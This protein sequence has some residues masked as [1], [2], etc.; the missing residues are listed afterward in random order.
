MLKER[1]P[2]VVLLLIVITFGIYA[3]VWIVKTKNEMNSLGANIPTAWFIIIPILNI[4]FFWRYCEGF[5]IITKKWEAIVI[6]LIAI[7]FAPAAVWIV[8]DG[9]NEKAV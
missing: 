7:I 5:A 8:Q 4:Y 1:N 3:L 6:F 9:L 2:L